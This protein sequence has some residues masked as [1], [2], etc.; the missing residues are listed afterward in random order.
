MF[1]VGMRHL[2]QH[3]HVHIGRLSEA[4]LITD[5]VARPSASLASHCQSSPPY[6]D[7]AHSESPRCPAAGNARYIHY[8]DACPNRSFM[9]VFFTCSSPAECIHRGQAGQEVLHQAKGCLAHSSQENHV[10]VP[11][12]WVGVAQP[13]ERLGG[14]WQP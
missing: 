7:P 12:R 3:G 10:Q 8:G 13:S 14:A 5:R 1:C 4:A 11:G 2:N 6:P 9:E